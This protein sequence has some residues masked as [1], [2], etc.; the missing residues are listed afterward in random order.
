M[1]RDHARMHIMDAQKW[2]YLL[3]I[4]LHVLYY[5][6]DSNQTY[7]LRSATIG[8]QL[9]VIRFFVEI[10]L[11]PVLCCVACVDLVHHRFGIARTLVALIGFV[12]CNVVS[13]GQPDFN[14]LSL[15]WLVV[16]CP[17]SVS[18]RDVARV[19]LAAG[20]CISLITITLALFGDIPN[21]A[22][23]EHGVLRFGLGFFRDFYLSANLTVLVSV[24][25]YCN[26][27]NWRFYKYAIAL[28]AGI[29]V[30]TVGNGRVAFAVLLIQL[31]GIALWRLSAAR[32]RLH[33]A[34]YCVV[35]SIAAFLP[36]VLACVSLWLGVYVDAGSTEL[37]G[38]RAA[39]GE[40][41]VG[42]VALW[43]V[44]IEE[45][46]LS[47]IG[48]T[49]RP[50]N[51]FDSTY[52]SMSVTYGIVF[53][54]LV[55]LLCAYCCLRLASNKK[56]YTLLYV[57]TLSVLG[58]TMRY[59]DDPALNISIF[60]LTVLIV[61]DANRRPL[62]SRATSA[63][64]IAQAI[65]KPRVRVRVALVMLGIV[66]IISIAAI[67][68]KAASKSVAVSAGYADAVGRNDYGQC[69]VGRWRGITG[70]SAGHLHTIG[71][72][73]D[74]TVVAKGNDYFGQC[75]VEDWSNI[76][77]VSA[78]Y[79]HTVGLRSDGS[80]VAI[81]ASGQNRCDV[82]TWKNVIAIAAGGAHTIGLCSDGTVLA[83]GRNDD[84]RCDVGEWRDVVAIDTSYRH[85]I[86]LRGD[87][88][89]YAAGNNDYGQC[90]VDDWTDIVAISAGY[91]HTIGVHSDGTVVAAGRIEDGA[92][93]VADWKTVVA[94]SAGGRHSIAVKDDGVF[95][96]CGS[97]KA[98]QCEIR[99]DHFFKP[100]TETSDKSN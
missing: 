30:Y 82:G 68:V 60:F 83:T 54:V 74:G 29:V 19:L 95:E 64:Q 10:A 93:E 49:G 31:V 33:V 50:T 66:T 38:L 75:D 85:V 9:Q 88:T 53:T 14:L 17:M 59:L 81:G 73:S 16:A 61:Q 87:G 47:F 94:V 56:Y 71:V 2:A 3:C 96:A 70:V 80:V 22:R 98:G 67:S 99:Y 34:L 91:Y 46:G 5:L 48:G 27:Q 97:D 58:F 44:G 42:R 11:V 15:Y 39:F 77:E 8:T 40:L 28:S 37:N 23:Y 41:L 6:S 21:V 7:L 100:Y 90:D 76:V 79:Q 1:I 26:L 92:C 51:T 89:V 4:A 55:C 12:V 32:E 65:K 52:L 25:V 18:E 84:G 86:A 24:W 13:G 20:L 62:P 72:R 63:H 57:A 35:R 45:V 78:G 69:N 43:N 36:L